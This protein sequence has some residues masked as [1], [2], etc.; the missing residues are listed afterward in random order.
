[1][2]IQ[3]ELDKEYKFDRMAEKFERTARMTQARKSNRFARKT[4]DLDEDDL[5]YENS[6]NKKRSY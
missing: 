6:F 1:M 2:G 4:K 3:K 5:Y